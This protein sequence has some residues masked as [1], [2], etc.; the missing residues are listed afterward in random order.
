MC[1]I[2]YTF[3]SVVVLNKEYGSIYFYLFGL[4]R[5]SAGVGQ[6]SLAVVARHVTLQAP[7]SRLREFGYV[8]HEEEHGLEMHVRVILSDVNVHVQIQSSILNKQKKGDAS[9]TTGNPS[10]LLR[11]R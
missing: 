11:R 7:S 1:T 5:H 4:T 6:P 9:C 8:P 2:A 3:K 10:G